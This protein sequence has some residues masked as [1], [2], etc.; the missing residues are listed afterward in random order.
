MEVI[1]QG[2]KRPE[3]EADHSPSCSVDVKNVWSYSAIYP[4]VY[5]TYYVIKYRNTYLS[6]PL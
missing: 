5:N 2:V 1:P 3:H 4:Y 6:S